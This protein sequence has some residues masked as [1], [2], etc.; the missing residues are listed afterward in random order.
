M[1]LR[2]HNKFSQQELKL[3]LKSLR[4]ELNLSLLIVENIIIR[5][6]LKILI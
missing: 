6:K 1:I 5:E 4:K 3:K 2:R